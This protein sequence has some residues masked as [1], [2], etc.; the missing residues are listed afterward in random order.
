MTGE[1]KTLLQPIF[2]T[3]YMHSGTTLVQTVL[4][5]NDKVFISGGETRHFSHLPIIKQKFPDLDDD[6]I[7]HDYIIYLLQV[8]CT[9][10]ARVN[11]LAEDTN[12]MRLLTECGLSESDLQQLMAVARTNRDYATLLGD[13]YEYL[14]LKAGKERWLDK[15][16]S[17]ITILDKIFSNYP[18]ACVIEMVRDPR[19]ILASKLR[20]SKGQGNYDPVWDSLSWRAAVHAG[21]NARQ[22]YPGKIMRVRYEDLVAD[23]QSAARLLCEFLDL[24]FVDSMLSVNWINTSIEGLESQGI[25]TGAMGKWRETLPASDVYICQQLTKR[26]MV[27]NNYPRERI[28]SAARLK[29]PIILGRSAG[30]FVSRLYKQ[31]SVGGKTQLL[32]VFDGYRVRL[33]ALNGSKSTKT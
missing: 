28:P 17:Y 12:P 2:V 15:S 16:P 10:Y 19:D 11:Y 20:R 31:W 21:D 22:Q 29:S 8:I 27:E 5:N 30:E 3:G 18:D 33:K 26:E 23:P 13:V 6:Q 7:L 24:P 4:G 25:G 1:N 14:T 9:G 32:N